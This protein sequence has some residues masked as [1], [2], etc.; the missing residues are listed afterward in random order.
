MRLTLLN[1]LGHALGIFDHSGISRDVMFPEV[2]E[3]T[4]GSMTW[5]TGLTQSYAEEPWTPINTKLSQ[6]DVNTLIRL[7]NCPGPLVHLK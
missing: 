4:E 6:R 1:E 7:Y 5:Q 2:H 3:K